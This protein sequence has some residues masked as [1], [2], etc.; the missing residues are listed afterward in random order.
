[1]LWPGGVGLC[2]LMNVYQSA[3]QTAPSGPTCACTGENHSSAPAI[4]F[5]PSRV[6]KPAPCGSMI[7]WPTRCAVGSVMN[8]IRF[9]YFFG[10]DRA[11]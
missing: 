2:W 11:V 4:R 3:I 5:Q 8:A 1:M 9:Q 6:T 7:P 10:N